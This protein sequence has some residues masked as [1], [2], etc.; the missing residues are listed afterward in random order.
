MTSNW[1]NKNPSTTLSPVYEE[2]TC[3]F[4]SLSIGWVNFHFMGVKCDFVFFISFFVEIALCKQNSPRWDA[5]F[6]DVTSGAMLFAYV[7]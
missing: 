7:P 4:P 3:H 1:Y 5:A 6:C 2:W